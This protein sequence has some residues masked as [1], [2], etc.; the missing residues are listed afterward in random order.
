MKLNVK[1]TQSFIADLRARILGSGTLVKLT[2]K[3][4]ADPRRAMVRLKRAR[5]H[6]HLEIIPTDA[7]LVEAILASGD[8]GGDHNRTIEVIL[9]P[10]GA[11]FPFEELMELVETIQ[12]SEEEEPNCL[13]GL[14]TRREKKQ[15]EALAAATHLLLTQ[16]I[17]DAARDWGFTL[18]TELAISSDCFPALLITVLTE[19]EQEAGIELDAWSGRWRA[20]GHTNWGGAILGTPDHVARVERKMLREIEDLAEALTD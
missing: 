10:T 1:S 4:D 20:A 12:R 15:E 6:R 9:K 7:L 19:D 17:K 2:F 13:A 8:W 14:M 18:K 16:A 5:D 11:Y 3:R